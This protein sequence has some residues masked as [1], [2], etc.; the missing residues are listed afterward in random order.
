MK[1]QCTRQRERAR[2][3]L[4]GPTGYRGGGKVKGADSVA[5]GPIV[6][7]VEGIEFR[8]QSAPP[9]NSTEGGKQRCGL[10]Q[11]SCQDPQEDGFGVGSE[12]PSTAGDKSPGPVLQTPVEE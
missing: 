1:E 11:D 6:H 3:R 2:H 4:S 10:K 8:E 12:A 7:S 5:K 9:R